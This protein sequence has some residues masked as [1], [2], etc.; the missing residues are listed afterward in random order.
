MTAKPAA[1]VTGASS[2][3]G[4]TYADRLAARGYDLVLVARRADRLA[5]LAS[6]LGQ[7]HGVGI[8]VLAADLTRDE[9][10]AR[11]EQV[12]E[13]NAALAL[14]V[15]NAGNGKL[16][17]TLQMSAVDAA[18]TITLNITALTRLTR[19]VLPQFLRRDAGSIINIASVAALHALASTSLYS[20]TKGFVLNFSR[21]L[22]E[23][24]AGTGVKVQAVLPAATATEFFDQAGK[25]ITA[26]DPASIMTSEDLVDAALAGFDRGEAVTLPSVE[27]IGLWTAYEAA[28]TQLFAATHSGCPATRYRRG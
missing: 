20:G 12:L 3:I 19:A 9:D 17:S 4:M 27:D 24:L 7:K 25:P 6:T 15:N 21:G 5:A 26:L 16:G 11:V 22:Q 28:R 8:E 14:L 10:L 18:S 2:G 1:L 23:E 13:S